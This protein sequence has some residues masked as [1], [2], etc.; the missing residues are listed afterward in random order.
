M[1]NVVI[2]DDE[3]P[4]RKV[5]SGLLT[6]FFPNKFNIL[7][8]CNSVDSA[9]IAILE[10]QPDLVFLDIKMKPKNGFELLKMLPSREFEVIFTTA[11]DEYAIKAIRFSALDYLL[12]P[13]NL[14]D[15]RDSIHRFE[16]IESKQKEFDK[17][18]ILTENLKTEN[19]ERIVFP[20]EKSIEVI[21]ISEI[22]YCKADGSYCAV[23]MTSG[24]S[25]LVAKPLKYVMDLLESS[26]FFKTHKSYMINTK[27]I[28]R[29]LKKE[30]QIELVGGDLIPVSFRK[31]SSLMKLLQQLIG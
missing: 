9:V 7:A 15:L 11:F 4:A 17:I 14:K 10:K 3:E 21:N 26:D 28:V 31:K 8:M 23:H 25:I 30:D 24:K 1:I 22:L 27:Q 20:T 29:F 6:E 13:I 18:K 19:L 5:I 2:V 16:K 12:K